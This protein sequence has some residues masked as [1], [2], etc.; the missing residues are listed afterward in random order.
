MICMRH[1]ALIYDGKLPYDMKVMSGVALYMQEGA[2]FI[3]YTDEDALK[4]QKLPDLRTWHGDGI[5][6]DF[7]DPKVA[8]AVLRSK[9]PAVGFGGGYGWYT[10]GRGIPYFFSDQCKIGEMAAEHL[11]DRGFRNFAFCDAAQSSTNVWSKERCR[12]F[13]ARLQKRGFSCSVYHPQ[14][15]TMR[16]WSSVL[17][18]LGKWLESLPKPTGIMGANDRRAYHV[19]EACRTYHIHVPEEV[20]VIGVDNDEMLCQ[21]SNPALSSIEQGAKQIGYQAAALLDRMMDGHRPRREDIVVPPIGVVTRKSTDVFSIEDRL[22]K[23]AMEYIRAHAHKGIAAANVVKVLGISRST[24]D[25][26]LRS[27]TGHSVHDIIRTVR[28]DRARYFVAETNLGIK[29][30]AANTGFKSVQ[31]MTT[32]FGKAFG[33]TPAEYRKNLIR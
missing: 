17:A 27:S 7:D 14:H 31:H 25:S 20:A 8:A 3:T 15:K 22:A 23:Q 12:A 19:L 13:A 29:A 4:D 21:L 33:Q 5:I 10:P 32:L 26:R 6:A 1:V 18:S 24:L 30:I 9:L 28:L 16:R 11:M 2:D